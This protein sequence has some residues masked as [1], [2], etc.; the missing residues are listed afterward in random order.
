MRTFWARALAL[1]AALLLALPLTL[2]SQSGYLCRM[3]DRITRDRCCCSHDSEV[4][5]APSTAPEIKAQDCCERV[6]GKYQKATP[7]LSDGNSRT[8]SPTVATVEAFHPALEAPVAHLT[9]IEP[10]QARAP[11]TPALKLFL[12]HCSFLT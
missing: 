4:A 2:M 1:L 3:M 11:P 12:R 5:Q 6:Q 10:R 9:P 8:F 7:S